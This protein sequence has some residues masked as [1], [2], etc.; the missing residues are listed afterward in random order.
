[1]S[2]A[3]AKNIIQLTPPITD[4]CNSRLLV[5]LLDG[6]LR[7]TDFKTMFYLLDILMP[8]TGAQTWATLRFRSA[9]TMGV[10][11]CTL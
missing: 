3:R 6:S 2:D 7:A 10:V 4:R 1:M 9:N 11:A 5:M 8:F